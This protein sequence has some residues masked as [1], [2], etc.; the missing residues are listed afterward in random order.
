MRSPG[1][2]TA[3]P[4]LPRWKCW[5]VDQS[6][7]KL[8]A[9]LIRC[10][11]SFWLRGKI[12]TSRHFILSRWLGALIGALIMTGFSAGKASAQ[13]GDP[14]S[15][16]QL[17]AAGNQFFGQV[18]GNIAAVIEEAISRF[19]LPNGYILG[20]SIGGALVG[21]LRYGEGIL[22]TQNVGNY[23]VYWQGPSIGF[24]AGAD[25]SSTMMLVYNLP[26]VEALYTR[27]FGVNGAAYV[28]GGVGMTVLTRN[29]IIIVPIVSGVGARLGLSVGYYKFTTQPTWNPF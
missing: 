2:P 3:P 16:N 1:L 28:V 14:Y 8:L 11:S 17:V 13:A 23:E 4:P 6:L 21:G 10:D 5:I 18:S 24:D 12:V 20:E 26:S 22:Y 15:V 25:A 29:D 27:F 19:G 7:A 9:R